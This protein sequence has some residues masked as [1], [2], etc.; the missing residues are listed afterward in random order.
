MTARGEGW[1]VVEG[2]LDEE[3]QTSLDG[4]MQAQAQ[5]ERLKYEQAASDPDYL[6]ILEE[7]GNAYTS[8][9]TFKAGELVQW[10]DHMR[11]RRYPQYGRPAIVL[12]NPSSTPSPMLSIFPVGSEPTHDDLLI[13]FLDGDFD[14][15]VLAVEG[16]RLQPWQE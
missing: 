16:A 13:G 12:G 8:P 7:V 2:T 6:N 15:V 4:K 14:L 11:N 5:E 10:R 9:H 3:I 1:E